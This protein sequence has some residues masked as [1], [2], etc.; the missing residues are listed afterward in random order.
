MTERDPTPFPKRFFVAEIDACRRIV[1]VLPEEMPFE[2]AK[3]L[4]RRLTRK[5]EPV[6]V[7][8]YEWLQQRRSV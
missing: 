3:T 1:R 7:S 8:H 2:E 4:A 6:A 5:F